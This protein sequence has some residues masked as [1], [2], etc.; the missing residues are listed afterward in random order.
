MELLMQDFRCFAGEHEIPV[1]PLTILTGENSSGKSSL[2]AALSVVCGHRSF[3]MRP[4]FNREPYNL[5]NFDTIVTNLGTTPTPKSFKLGYRD[6][7]VESIAT[8][9]SNEGQVQLAQFDYLNEEDTLKL[10]TR[11][12]EKQYEGTLAWS[13][14]G[15]SIFSRRF[16]ARSGFA[17]REGFLEDS[18][19]EGMIAAAKE[20]A[21]GNDSLQTAG[22]LDPYKDWERII[23]TKSFHLAASVPPIR[24]KPRRTYDLI[25]DLFGMSDDDTPYRIATMVRGRRSATG[26]NVLSALER[27]GKEA[28]LFDKLERRNLGN[29]ASDPFQLLVKKGTRTHNLID[30]GYG[31]SQALPVIFE[32]VTHEERLLLLQQPEVHLHPQAQA[33]LGSFFA[34]FVAHGPAMVVAETH[35]DYIVD[36]IRQEV[37]NG[38][39]NSERVQILFFEMTP[40]GAK[41]HQLLLDD[42]GNVLNAPSSYRA[43][44][45]K[46]ELNLL[47]RGQ[48]RNGKAKSAKSV[49]PHVPHH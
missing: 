11:N 7:A 12:S 37:A 26:R 22:Q 44:F 23:L 14:G 29:K 41:V 13:R 2:L 40:K 45:L 43:F 39:I 48:Q 5:G 25:D 6:A 21:M 30:V 28:G 20:Q 18:L 16:A 46:E 35:S 1:R 36:R 19:L 33:A 27:F 17:E 4:G 32:C 38:S 8:Y 10:E 34:S 42:L 24:A 3:P 9:R 15:K 47:T 49:K 31:V